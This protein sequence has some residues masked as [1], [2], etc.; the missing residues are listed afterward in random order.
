MPANLRLVVVAQEFPYPP[1]HG[2]RADVWRRLCAMKMSGVQIAL[3]CWYDD[4][5]RSRPS[6]QDLAKVNEVAVLVEAMPV[7][8]GLGAALRRIVRIAGGV[9]SH[10]AARMMDRPT[11]MRLVSRLAEFKPVA[12]LLES[13]YGGVF[14]RDV[15]KHLDV[16]LYYRSHNIE[17]RY[18]AG[19][20]R[21][22][23]QWRDRLAWRLAC[24]HLARFEQR[25]MQQAKISFDISADDLVYWRDKGVCNGTWLPP[26][27]EPALHNMALVA[28]GSPPARE[29][30]YLGNL[31]APN[32]VQALHWLVGEVMPIVWQRRPETQLTIGGSHP[33]AVVRTLVATH[34]Q[35]QLLENVGD[36]PE[37]LAS[38][39][40]LVNPARSG[41]GVNVKTLDML[42]TDRVVVST[43]QGV[44]GLVPQIKALCRIADSPAQFAEEVLLALQAPTIELAARAAGR[45]LFSTAAVEAAV[46]AMS[47]LLPKTSAESRK[48]TDTAAAQ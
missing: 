19:Q 48:Q 22:A 40:V 31:H 43:S 18:F 39:T 9:P 11:S 32:N 14:A 29:V 23:A 1:L 12:V 47:P 20:A 21:A 5:P 30:V 26:L 34:P 28:S 10:A 42:M 41:S 16:P 13:P 37:L 44:A 15:C 6:A 24:I 45:Q 25:L 4:C 8:R 33:G 46:T 7:P 35:V 36:A 3:V 38:A 17:H 27:P 2:G